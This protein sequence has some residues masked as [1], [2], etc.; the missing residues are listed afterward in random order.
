MRVEDRTHE[1]L[2]RVEEKTENNTSRIDKLEDTTSVL[3]EMKA[4]LEMQVKINEKQSAQMEQSERTFIAMNENLTRIGGV[5]NQ[6]QESIVTINNRVD[7]VI[8][9]Q[10]KGKMSVNDIGVKIF[11]GLVMIIPTMITAWV[12]IKS[13]L[14]P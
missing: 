7:K 13:G 8:A 2:A 3:G 4:I 14:K 9:D 12:M 5:T 11:Y 10:D 6:L 1:R